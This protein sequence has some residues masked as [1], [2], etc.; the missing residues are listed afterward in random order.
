MGK[1]GE[2]QVAAPTP[3]G[4]LEEALTLICRGKNELFKKKT[5]GG[6]ISHWL[7]K[8]LGEE[9]ILWEHLFFSV[10]TEWGGKGNRFMNLNMDIQL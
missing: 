7:E 9:K 4:C 8:M 10:C 6:V 5:V 3:K 2:A 1:E